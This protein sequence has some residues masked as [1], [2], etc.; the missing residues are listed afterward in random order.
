MA[1]FSRLYAYKQTA[2]RGAFEDFLT[3]LLAQWLRLVDDQGMS[4]HVLKV[5]FKLKPE[6]MPSGPID[7]QTQHVIGK[8]FGKASRRRPDLIATG[9]GFFLIVENKTGA[10]FGVHRDEGSGEETPQLDVYQGYLEARAARGIMERSALCLLTFATQPPV[11][12]TGP[13]CFWSEVHHLLRKDVREGK[14]DGGSALGFVTKELIQFLEDNAMG[15]IEL[16]ASDLV[17]MPAIRRMKAAMEQLQALAIR[18]STKLHQGRST[19][20]QQVLLPCGQGKEARG[21][22]RVPWFYG[23]ILTQEGVSFSLTNMAAWCGLMTEACDWITP[24]DEDIPEV[25]VGLAI[26]C[27]APSFDGPEE[28]VLDAFKNS[29]NERSSG[30][31][32]WQRVGRTEYGPVMIFSVRILLTDVWQEAHSIS[33]DDWAASFFNGHLGG[34][35]GALRDSYQGQLFQDILADWVDRTN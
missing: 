25:T 23:E 15:S 26:W 30:A 7:W 5:L 8:G 6:Q 34:L 19:G 12:W 17:A 27:Y 24:L 3:E 18:E 32:E 14:V 10:R 11:D 35:L 31:W 21:D 20:A 29:V 33:W 4:E 16:H 1:F 13:V 28:Q 22:F 9:E 2:T